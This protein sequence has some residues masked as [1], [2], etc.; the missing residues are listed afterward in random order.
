MN[1]ILY[2]DDV[3]LLSHWEKALDNK[4]SVCE[5]IDE[6][7]ECESSLIIVNYS[8]CQKSCEELIQTLIS[9]NNRVLVLHRV[10]TLITGKKLLKSG[11]MGYGNAMMREHF[12]LS[13]I[14]TIKD[15]MIW[16]YPEF[17]S[18]LIQQIPSQNI[19]NEVQLKKLSEREKDV[20][21][22]LKDGDTYKTVAQ[23]LDITPRTV[24]AHATGIYAKLGVKDRIGLALLLK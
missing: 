4:C 10:P 18:E 5:N 24:K 8:A 7:F 6:L 20:A 19:A 17:T 21:I 16:L 11:A 22:L 12:I 23:K 3:N 2:S 1:T 9:H 15:N 13:A 14:E